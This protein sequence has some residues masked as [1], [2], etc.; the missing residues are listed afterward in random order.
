MVDR[1]PFGARL[2]RLLS[3]RRPTADVSVESLRARLARDADV[4]SVELG[5]VVDGA[6]PTPELIRRLAPALGAPAA[7]LFVVAGLPVP[8]D[9]APAGPTRPWDVGSLLLHAVEL[10]PPRLAELRA[11]VRS[12]PVRPRSAPA[13]ADEYP[14]GP[15]ALLL[16]LLRNRNIKP[17][18]ARLLQAVGDSPYVSHATVAMLGPG[19]VTA[20]PRY[21]TAFA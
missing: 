18:N 3:A 16:R 12:L 21:V 8:G 10:T 2:W 11:L 4:S 6:E 15:G 14:D 5:A 13:P 17:Y 7:D 9:L 19:R 20:T 1:S